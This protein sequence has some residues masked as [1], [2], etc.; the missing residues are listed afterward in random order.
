MT[1]LFNFYG[2]PSSG[3]TTAAAMAFVY[4]KK[5]GF[6]A[7][8]VQE[9]ATE[10]ILA[11]KE[12]LLL[13]QPLLFEE[14][15]RRIQIS[16]G[17]VDFIMV[18]SPLLLNVVF[19]RLRTPV[20]DKEFEQRVIDA[21]REFCQKNILLAYHPERYSAYGRVTTRNDSFMIDQF[22]KNVLQETQSPYIEFDSL[23]NLGNNLNTV[24]EKGE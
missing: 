22:I 15:L 3:K 1:C 13:N 16:Y 9:Y 17:K 4:A 19:H 2:A 18:D 24:F 20:P 8:L 6:S 23:E 14:Q 10:L 11:G 7:A 5:H 12:E 21:D